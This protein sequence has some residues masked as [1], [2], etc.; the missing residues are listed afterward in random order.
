M[1]DVQLADRLPGVVTLW[2]DPVC[3]FTW[4]TA[5]WLE[6]AAGKAGFDID[7]RLM[8]LAVLNEGRELPPTQQARMADSRRVGRLMAAVREELGA[9]GFAKAYFAFGQR[10]FDHSAAVDDVLVSHVLREAGSSQVT[11]AALSDAGLDAAVAE[12]HRASQ[13]A[14]GEDGGSP[15]LTIGDRTF[16]GPVFTAAPAPDRT[17]AVF[18]AVAALALTP[19]FSQMQRPRNHA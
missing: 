2:L 8:S 11:A 6:A 17:L 4:N 7:W 5:R 19:E 16:F 12:S 15:M 14:L 1:T 9:D 3:P 10:Y 18:D 13:A